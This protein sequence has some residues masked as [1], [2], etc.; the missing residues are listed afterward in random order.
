M[1]TMSKTP[2]YRI[3]QGMKS[4][5]CSPRNKRYERYGGRGITVCQRWMDSF[6]NFFADMGPRPSPKHSI[7][8]IDNDGNYEPDNC[9]WATCSQQRQNAD[10]PLDWESSSQY[11]GVSQHSV[12]CNRWFSQIGY[13]GTSHRIGYHK[14]EIEA[15]EN[16]DRAA[17]KHYGQHARLNFP[18]KYLEYIVTLHTSVQII[19]TQCETTAHIFT[20]TAS[21]V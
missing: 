1:A 7:D 14:T 18:H 12:Y 17:V 11:R 13:G 5:C 6:A 15:A 8:R 2:E 16:Y 9:R 3:W 19:T 20:Q 4:R 21:A 10:R